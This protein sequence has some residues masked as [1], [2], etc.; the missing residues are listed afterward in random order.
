MRK[1]YPR[2]YESCTKTRFLLFPKRIGIE[3]RWLEEASWKEEF[4]PE[5]PLLYPNVLDGYWRPIKWI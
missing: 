2:K 4:I 5:Y 3:R 1:Q